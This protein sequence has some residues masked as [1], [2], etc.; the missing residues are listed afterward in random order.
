MPLLLGL[1]PTITKVPIKG[2]V[3][4]NHRESFDQHG[5]K[6]QHFF[7]HPTFGL[8]AKTGSLSFENTR[9][10]NDGRKSSLTSQHKPTG[11]SSHCL[12]AKG[13]GSFL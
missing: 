5:G 9:T 1:F 8:K 13:D 7:G 11:A 2:A 3:P 6:R 10:P 12:Q 4:M